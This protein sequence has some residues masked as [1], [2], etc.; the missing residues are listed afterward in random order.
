MTGRHLG[1]RRGASTLHRF[2]LQWAVVALPVLLLLSGTVVATA[3]APSIVV[4]TLTVASARAGTLPAG[5]WGANVRPYYPLDSVTSAAFNATP[6]TTLR[7]P[8]GATGDEYNYTANRLYNNNG[9]YYVPPT[10]ESD[11]IAFCRSVQ[12]DA[13]LQLPGE[14]DDPSTAAYYVSYTV[15]T[16]HFTP[17]YWEIGNEPALW[18]HFGIAWTRWTTTQALNATPG[19]YAAVVHSYIA[20]I[21]AVDPQ[22]SF[23][24]LSGV[25]TGGYH[26]TTWIRATVALNGPNLSAVAIHVYP[27]GGST[28]TAS[29]TAATFYASLLGNGGLAARIPADRL[30]IRAGCPTCGPI[31]LLVTELGSG[32]QG[33]PYSRYMG[34]Y[35]DMV[36]LS[37]EIAQAVSLV[38]PSTDIFA[39]QS[40]YNGS[41]LSANGSET[42][43]FG[44]YATLFGHLPSEVLNCSIAGA[45]PGVFSA[46]TRSS[47]SSAYALLVVNTNL[48]ASV[49]FDLTGSGFPVL[50]GGTAWTW[51]ASQGGV[52]AT[53]WLLVPPLA[54]VVPPASV[55]LMTIG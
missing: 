38:I 12:C 39:W 7:W 50:G 22:A 48:T 42:R 16:L 13:I 29:P 25:G 27:A 21:R 26:E 28:T 47:N 33:G 23:I 20:A 53:N 2:G 24:G 40:T 44:L 3:P 35:A 11:F 41:L 55:L 30:A 5:F 31:R 10:N 19:S 46:A 34:G 52:Q 37:A 54:W 4:G 45:P 36:Y 8:G 17:A 9:S 32:T 6:L 49:Q 15:H 51:V 14:I 1:G 43:I 18:T